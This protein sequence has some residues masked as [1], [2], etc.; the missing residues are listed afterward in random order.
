MLWTIKSLI[1]LPDFKPLRWKSEQTIYTAQCF[2]WKAAAQYVEGKNL[3]ESTAHRFAEV[4]SSP[5]DIAHLA[6]EASVALPPPSMNAEDF[7]SFHLPKEG[8]LGCFFSCS[9]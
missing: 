1:R 2:D 7:S 5:Q 9:T 4:K 6:C 8:L 3:E